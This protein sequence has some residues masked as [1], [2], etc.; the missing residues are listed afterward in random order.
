MLGIEQA[1][2]QPLS[3]VGVHR[4]ALSLGVT[5]HAH[6]ESQAAVC[7]QEEGLKG[8]KGARKGEH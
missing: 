1:G 4:A 6:E 5:A 3:T 2:R 8:Q 7:K